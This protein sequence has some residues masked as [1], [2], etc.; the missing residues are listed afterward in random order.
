MT[1]FINV[2]QVFPWWLEGSIPSANCLIAYRPKGAGDYANSKINLA[3]PG[4][5]NAGDGTAYPTWDAVNGWKFAGVSEQFLK[6]YFIPVSGNR[7][8]AIIKFSNGI[9]TSGQDLDFIFAGGRNL[10]TQSRFYISGYYNSSGEKHIYGWNELVTSA[11]GYISSGIMCNTSGKGY[12]NG[13]SDGG[14]ISDFG[15]TGYA[16]ALGY[17]PNAA[18]YAS[19]DAYATAYVQ[20][21]ALYDITLSQPQVVAITKNM[22][23]L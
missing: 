20:A 18:D 19:G 1:K 15:N 22:S 16:S 5:Y 13:V 2:D 10:G 4:T 11:S 3:N 23:V 14:T 12:L 9:L 21:F 6:I 8:S 17:Q 7:Y